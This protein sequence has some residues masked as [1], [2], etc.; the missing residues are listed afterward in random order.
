VHYL[1]VKSA[2]DINKPDKIF[3]YYTFEPSG[4][5]WEKDKGN[6]RL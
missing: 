5:W 4:E 2:Y 6:C 3:L 1:A